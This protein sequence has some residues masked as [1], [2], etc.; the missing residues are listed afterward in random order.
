MDKDVLKDVKVVEFSW[1]LAGPFCTKAIADFG[2]TV[3]RVESLKRPELLRVSPPYKDGIPGVNRA[4]WFATLNANKLSISLDLN[5]P[6]AGHVVKGLV[7]W[8]DIVTENFVPGTAKRWGI[9]YESLRKIKDDIIFL[10]ASIQGQTGP[11]S[12]QPGFGIQ[13]TALVGMT[14]I[15]GWP[16]RP[17]ALPYSG[18]TDM[19]LPLFGSV[20]LLG[21]LEY[22][23]RTG[24]GQHLDISQYE[25]AAQFIAPLL[26]DYTVNGREASRL[27][28]VCRHAIPHAAYPCKGEDRWCVI[29]VSNDEEWRAFCKVIGEPLWTKE[30]RFCTLL[31]RKQ[32][33]EELNRLVSEWTR[34]FAAEEVMTMMQSAGVPAGVVETFKDILNDPQLKSR[35]NF[36][37]MDHKEIGAIPQF[38]EPFVLSHTPARG[39]TSSPLLGEHTEY[40]CK[41]LLNMSEGEYVGLLLDDV[42]K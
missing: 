7:E 27:G 31:G 18:Y 3:V 19:I 5:H 39:R 38:G 22:R 13:A 11:N 40:V 2:G 17:P 20:S 14:E 25:T 12:L 35:G 36:W 4:G 34:G 30:D 9:D 41:E 21:A 33:E 32:N 1:I 37:L 23:R 8:A 29:A 15:T 42:F 10:Q 28:N 6:K 26:L 24:K 16:D